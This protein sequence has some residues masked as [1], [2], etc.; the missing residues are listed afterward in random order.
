LVQEKRIKQVNLREDM[1]IKIISK[2]DITPSFWDGGKTYEYFISPANSNFAA[3]DFEFRIS[4]ASIEKI[5]S[6]FTNFKGYQRY[7][8]MLD[9]ELKVNRNG[10]DEVYSEKE[11]FEFD[12]T[13]SIQSFSLGNDFNLMIK[14]EG[15]PFDLEVKTLNNDLESS[16]VFIFTLEETSVKINQQEFKLNLNDLLVVE[17]EAEIIKSFMSDKNVI[18]GWIRNSVQRDRYYDNAL[19]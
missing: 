14:R 4:S 11:I 8:V 1:N 18:V 19:F 10:V 13:D 7:L 3:R 15:S 17:N 12:S 16:F 2:N 6:S 9:N 5:P